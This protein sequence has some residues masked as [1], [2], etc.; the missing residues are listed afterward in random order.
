[1]WL[2]S[3]N[4][5]LLYIEFNIYVQSWLQ[6]VEPVVVKFNTNICPTK[7]LAATES[8]KCR[9]EL[10]KLPLVL[11]HSAYR[12]DSI[13]EFRYNF[14]CLID[15][16][17]IWLRSTDNRFSGP[18]TLAIA[19]GRRSHLSIPQKVHLMSQRS[20]LT[21]GREWRCFY[22]DFYRV[23]SR[24]QYRLQHNEWLYYF[25]TWV[26]L[27]HCAI[28][29]QMAKIQAGVLYVHTYTYLSFQTRCFEILSP[30]IGIILKRI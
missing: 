4:A 26:L 18:T 17:H 19:L 15:I 5:T 9:S 13:Y 20:L 11:F 6:S 22:C 1:M 30:D 23:T 8:A 27:T 12:L 2:L 21:P 24:L 7:N 29:R 10:F 28:Y 25:Y 14:T 16:T 3:N